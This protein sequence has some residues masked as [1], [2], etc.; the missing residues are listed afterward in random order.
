[1][2][3]WERAKQTEQTK[4]GLHD[5]P[6]SEHYKIPEKQSKTTWKTKGNK[7]NNYTNMKIMTLK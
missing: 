3:G 2:R 1:M 7:R 4:I 6:A 5:E